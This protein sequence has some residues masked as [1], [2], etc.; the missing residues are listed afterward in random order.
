MPAYHHRYVSSRGAFTSMNKPHPPRSH[1][2]MG[3]QQPF[4]LNITVL[5]WKAE[6]SMRG[7]GV[8]GRGERGGKGRTCMEELGCGMHVRGIL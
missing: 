5:I 4:T 6:G 8:G 7:E 2:I 1:N 3:L